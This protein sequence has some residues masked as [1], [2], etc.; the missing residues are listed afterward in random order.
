MS[1]QE[2]DKEISMEDL[3]AMMEEGSGEIETKEDILPAIELDLSNIF[4]CKINKEKFQKGLDSGSEIL[5]FI[6]ALKQG[7][8]D[9]SVALNILLNEHTILHNIEM[10]KINSETSKEVSKNQM[11][12]AEKHD[13]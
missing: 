11:V 7:G 3:I 13:L 12:V 10:A 8:L 1:E 6:T 2:K 5:G 4:D 9:S